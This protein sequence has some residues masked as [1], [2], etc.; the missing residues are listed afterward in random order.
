MNKLMLPL[1]LC[2]VRE[3]GRVLVFASTIFMFA[4]LA[5][6]DWTRSIRPNVKPDQ[7][8]ALKSFQSPTEVADRYS[9]RVRGY[10]YPPQ[11]GDYVF[12]ITSDDQSKLFLSTSS[13][14]KDK[15][16]IASA[17]EW[18]EVGHYSKFPTQKSKPIQLVAGR[19]YYLEAIH[20]E[21]TG[22][23]H[24]GVGWL[25]PGSSAIKIIPG[26]NLSPFG[27]GEKGK[28]IQEVWS[29]PVAP[30]IKGTPVIKVI[31]KN[32]PTKPVPGGV[33]WFWNNHQSNLQKTKADN[34]DVCFLGD[35]ITSGWPGDLM[36]KYSGKYRPA[37]FGIGGDRAE[38]V[39]FRLNGGELAWT[40]PTVI[41]L[42][43]GVNNLSMG[44]NPGE[45]ALGVSTVITKLRAV[46]PDTKILLMGV[47]P[48]KLAGHNA[49]IPQVN[50]YLAKMDD[51]KMIRF[52]NI[53]ANFMDKD[54]KLRNELMKDDVHLSRNGYV[55]WGQSMAPLLDQMLK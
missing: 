19:K 41:V 12:G 44:N 45:V 27:A 1:L 49:R 43:L 10:V 51:G 52:L 18:T 13:D 2:R 29:D 48:T 31:S 55:I 21:N 37:N 11:T 17:S 20:R 53:N 40:N 38:N 28:I 6:A 50:A 7:T 22:G 23:D 36:K 8:V 25:V 32:D 42:L 9:S 16:L 5:S 35:S 24:L 46:V 33:R 34:F 39:L 15:Q 54:G 26:A 30:P 14:P 3:A 47:F 4:P